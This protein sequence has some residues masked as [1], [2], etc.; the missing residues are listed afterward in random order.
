M[1]RSLLKSSSKQLSILH[2][3]EG[4]NLIWEIEYINRFFLSNSPPSYDIPVFI[5]YYTKSVFKDIKHIIL[6]KCILIL[7]IWAPKVVIFAVSQHG[8]VGFVFSRLFLRWI[9]SVFLIPSQCSL[10]PPPLLSE[11]SGWEDGRVGRR[12]DGETEGLEVH[13]WHQAVLTPVNI[14]PSSLFSSPMFYIISCV[15][16]SILHSKLLIYLFKMNYWYWG[17]ML[18]IVTLHT[19]AHRHT[20]LTADL[21][22]MSLIFFFLTQQPIANF[23]FQDNHSIS[24]LW[25]CYQE[26]CLWYE[27]VLKVL[28]SF[29]LCEILEIKRQSWLK[30]HF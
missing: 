26:Y 21:H 12:K 13:D 15:P 30:I 27:E 24:L 3:C 10:F 18:G 7:D 8:S 5:F 20:P 23:C 11:K 1:F 29:L 17:W 4:V 19:C 22:I 16:F 2:S 25:F 14:P 6:V 28:F 9:S